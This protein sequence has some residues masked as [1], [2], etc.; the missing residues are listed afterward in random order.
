MST[1]RVWLA[2]RNMR[3]RRVATHLGV[4]DQVISRWVN[5]QAP[6]PAEYVGPL[7]KLLKKPVR[8]VLA[9]AGRVK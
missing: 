1:L 4:T 7:A 8:E 6:I 2:E 5:R 3:Q 9:V